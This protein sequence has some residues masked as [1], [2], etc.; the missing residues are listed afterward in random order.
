MRQWGKRSS[1]KRQIC[2]KSSGEVMVGV[3]G[4]R[5]MVHGTERIGSG[6]THL[7]TNIYSILS[8]A[9]SFTWVYFAWPPCLARR[10]TLPVDSIG[11]NKFECRMNSPEEF[12]SIFLMAVFLL[13]SFPFFWLLLL[14]EAHC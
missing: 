2:G 3:W 6:E 13:L 9:S 11:W 12:P 10:L 4:D 14:W 1:G 5:Y 7:Y 8:R